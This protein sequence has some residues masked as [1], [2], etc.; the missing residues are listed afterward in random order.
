MRILEEKADTKRPAIVAAATS[1]FANRGI[2]GTS[3]RD[4]ADAAGVREA[5]IYRHFQG[6]EQM[7]LQI[8]SSWYGWY[9][10]QVNEIVASAISLR[11]KLG[12]LVTLEFDAAPQPSGGVPVLLRQRIA[13]SADDGPGHSAGARRAH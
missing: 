12:A 10:R 7:A 1:L 3:M 5:A 4:V 13:F 9:S 8:F 6:K 11:K 2:D